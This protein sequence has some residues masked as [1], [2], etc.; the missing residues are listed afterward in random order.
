MAE[1]HGRRLSQSPNGEKTKV[2]SAPSF[3]VV[4]SVG[5]KE[6]PEQGEA[7]H[8]GDDGVVVQGGR[9]GGSRA[10]T[11][12]AEHA[13]GSLELERP[14]INISIEV[15]LLHCA[16]AECYR[17]LQPPIFKCEG[18]HL[19]CGACRGGRHDEGHCGKCGRATAFLHCGLELDAFVG[20]ARVPCPFQAYGCARSVAYH[21]A[22]AHQDACAYAPCHCSEA[23]CP[24]T[25]SP[26]RL[27][28]HLAFDHAWPVGRLPAYGKPFPLRA[29]A[30]EPH[31]LLVVEGDERHLFALSVRPHGAASCAVS[32]SCVR[33]RAAAESGPRFTC[34]LWAKAKTAAAA[35]PGGAARRLMMETDVGSCAVPGG[36]AVDEGMALYVPPPMLRGPSKEMDLRVRI[37][38][39]DPAPACLQQKNV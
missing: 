2:L 8:G 13:S 39:V 35:A 38:M 19:L 29:A 11:A 18:G 5:A 14:R 33:T 31:R 32:V 6:E 25:G 36:T 1:E 28:D 24:F 17:P 30:S 10:E 16:V 21:A 26:P 9:G 37:D 20:D 7:A 27:R 15:Q 4:P 22:A 12:V 3:P 34:T 23:G